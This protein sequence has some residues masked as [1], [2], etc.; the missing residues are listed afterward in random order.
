MNLSTKQKQ[1]RGHREQTG[2]CQE[3]VG[4]GE[5]DLGV[6]DQQI[7]TITYRMGGEGGPTVQDRELYSVSW[8]K[9]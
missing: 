9:P 3:E 5:M 6:W 1:T 8:D 4:R 2:G 7:Q